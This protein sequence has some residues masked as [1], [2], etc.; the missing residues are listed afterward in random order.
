MYWISYSTNE[1]DFM[2]KFDT[3]KAAYDFFDYFD[4]HVLPHVDYRSLRLWRNCEVV[5]RIRSK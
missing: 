3:R 5:R 1:Q 4:A 2:F